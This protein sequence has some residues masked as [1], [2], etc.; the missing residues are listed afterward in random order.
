MWPKK[1]KRFHFFG[2]SQKKRPD[3]LFVLRNLE[4]KYLHWKLHARSNIAP[5]E[6]D[7]WNQKWI[8]KEWPMYLPSFLYSFVS[9]STLN[10][11]RWMDSGEFRMIQL[12]WM[13]RK[14]RE[15]WCNNTWK[16]TYTLSYTRRPDEWIN[17]IPTSE[18]YIY[19]SFRIKS[20]FIAH[21]INNRNKRN[22]NNGVFG[23]TPL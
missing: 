1:Q 3:Y 11:Q 22:F 10:S 14:Q 21:A 20:Q 15:T 4:Y 2:D 8:T 9:I 18:R 19:Q 6:W 7:K 16:S 12:S 23:C 13:V 17:G 5:T